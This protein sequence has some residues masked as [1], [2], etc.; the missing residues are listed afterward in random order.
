MPYSFENCSQWKESESMEEP[1]STQW[2]YIF[3]TLRLRPLYTLNLIVFSH[4][5]RT[6]DLSSLSSGQS[7]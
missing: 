5:I 3:I 2:S 1:Q 7:S 6:Q 4:Q